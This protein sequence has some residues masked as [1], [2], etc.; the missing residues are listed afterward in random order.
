MNIRLVIIYFLLFHIT[1]IELLAQTSTT[2]G[3]D[4]HTGSTWIGGTV[5][6]TN[7]ATININGS[8]TSAIDLTFSN[9]IVLTVYTND[10]LVINGNLTFGNGADLVIQQG[11]VLIVRGNFQSNN[12]LE[13][14]ANAYLIVTGNFTLK[15]NSSLTSST[16]PS[17][18]F[19]GG[20]VSIGSG[21]IGNV[22]TCPGNTG[23]NSD[24][25]YGNLVDLIQDSIFITIGGTCTPQPTYY[26][27]GEPVSNSPVQVGSTINL[28][29]NPNPG[30]EAS[31]ISYAWSGANGFTYNSYSSPNTSIGSATLSMTG[32]YVFVA[33]NNQ[34]CYIRD[35]I[36]VLISDCCPSGGY[37][38]RNNY[39]GN[40]ED[41]SSWSTTTLTLPPPSNPVSSQYYCINGYITLNGDLRTNGGQQYVCDTLVVTGDFYA[42]NP[43]LTVGPNGL[44]IILGDYLGVSGT[45]TNNGRVV[46]VGEFTQPYNLSGTGTYYV[47]DPTPTVPGWFSTPTYDESELETNDVD[48]ND[49]LQTIL[50]STGVSGGAIGSSETICSGDEANEIINNSYPSPGS[51]FTYSW[52]RSTTSSNPSSGTWTL[53]TDSTR[54][55]L[56]PEILTLTTSYYRRAITGSGCPAL[57]NVVTVSVNPLPTPS[58]TSG[59]TVSCEQTVDTYTTDG[60]GTITWSVTG[61]SI[62]SGQGTS[63]VSIEW[64]TINPVFISDDMTLTVEDFDGSCTGTDMLDITIYRVPQTGPLYTIENALV[65]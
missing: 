36:Y 3:G 40:W 15:N 27:G 17:Q 30:S 57:S 46:F 6:A 38:S 11:A 31:F 45:I 44:L 2:T 19:I 65:Y 41:E 9:N 61:G 59:T 14:D 37:A 55:A 13:L 22:L 18:V 32:E 39:T 16:T 63:T 34:G 12:N 29:A 58:I 43:T 24:C 49:F 62:E 20:Q 33:F 42:D 5:P 51:T 4:W 10:T 56:F 35:S 64:N 21:T 54:E 1:L 28:S 8:V 47:F 48:L 60:T 26:S 25:N 7:N 53:I 50:C 23:Y 52:Y